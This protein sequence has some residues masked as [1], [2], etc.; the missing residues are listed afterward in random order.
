MKF[1]FRKI[2]AIAV[3][4][5]MAGMTLGVA[6]A[7]T[8]YPQPFV[9][10]GGVANVAVVYGTGTAAAPSDL[11]QAGLIQT[12][13]GT[14]VKGGTVSVTGGEAFSLQKSSNNF[15]FN[16][17]LN[18]VYTSL[19]DQQMPTF[20]ADGTYDD[21][22]VNEDY[23][24]KITLGSTEKLNLFADNDYDANKIP[25]LGFKWTN[26]QNILEYDMKMNAAITFSSM[27]HTN[28]P[29]MGKSYYVLTSKPSE[30]VLL[31]SANAETVAYGAGESVVVDGK[32]V[33]VDFMDSSHVKFNVDGELTN[34]LSDHGYEELSDG[35]YIV[36][37][38]ILYSDKE[39]GVSKVE[40]SIGKGK[41]SLK[42]GETVEVNDKDVDGLVATI[43]G[44]TGD[45]TNL[46]LTWNSDGETFLTE[47]DA[48]T[49]P[50]FD[51]IKVVYGGLDFPTPEQISIDNGDTI[52]LSMGNYDLPLFTIGGTLGSA[53]TLGDDG[54]PLITKVLAHANFTGTTVNN[55]N[56]FG[57]DAL[58]GGLNLMEDNTFLVTNLNDDLG[59]VDTAYYRVD[60]I[61]LDSSKNL[62]VVLKDLTG[63][64]RDLEFTDVDDEQTNGDITVTVRQ[65]NDTNVYLWFNDSSGTISYNTAVSDTGMEVT[66]PANSSVGQVN[67]L[68]IGLNLLFVEANND[69]KLGKGSAFN[70]TVK[71]TSNNKLHVSDTNLSTSYMY[72]E[73]SGSKVHTGYNPSDLTSKVTLDESGDEYDF[74]IDYY[75]KEV[76]ADVQVV[77]GEATVT[78]GT[79]N[80]G[81]VIYKDTEVSSYA[82][83]NV[84]VVGG[85]CINSA[86]A[87]LLGSNV[88][89]C[90]TAWTTATGI[91]EG[92]FLIKG[93]AS[94]TITSG[95]ALLVAGYEADDTVKA[96]TYLT[97]KVVDTTKAWK[98]TTSTQIATVIA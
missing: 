82:T 43:D 55:T 63:Q 66:L 11:V 9:S 69:G 60:K 97:N 20:L 24:Q 88:P 80:L 35:S 75:G 91:G 57:S 39:T 47:A 42:D 74:N 52:T 48:I 3:S 67:N 38:D 4:A 65:A 23:T 7:A 13:L 53:S 16:D 10:T 79:S 64:G 17:A 94:S 46:N 21:N 14:F 56:W 15:N 29:L 77:G 40:F 26:G 54:Y 41:I 84:I 36:A 73:S 32:T 86:A 31:D 72:L 49:M 71:S 28:M 22:D 51:T 90:G 44:A 92:Q 89:V 5:I 83:K 98:G 34:K 27:N 25:T 59:D 12:S 2:S 18:S 1:N 61:N 85:S 8:N 30:I 93:Y 78:S 33:S 68:A 87:K 96:T 19:T 50:V 95:V 70:V 58:A 45:F 6:A 62:D 37:N 81:N 76:T